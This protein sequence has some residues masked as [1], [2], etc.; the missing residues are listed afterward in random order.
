VCMVVLVQ[1]AVWVHLR[2]S[3]P[4][5]AAAAFRA[6]GIIG[7]TAG[8][9]FGLAVATLS[10]VRLGRLIPVLAIFAFVTALLSTLTF[11]AV[12]SAVAWRWDR[13][14]RTV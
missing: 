14:H 13:I 2:R 11:G 9:V 6:G 4:E 7:V 1:M 3:Q 8:V 12:A 5:S 10:V